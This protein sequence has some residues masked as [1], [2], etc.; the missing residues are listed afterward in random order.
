MGAPLPS[1]G[2]KDDAVDDAP[3]SELLRPFVVVAVLVAVMGLGELI[4]L[5]PGTPFD[6]WGIRPRTGRGLVGIVLAPFLHDGFGHLLA[7]ALPF[8]LMGGAIAA[9]GLGRFVRVAVIVGLVSGAGTW[10][11]GTAGS[12][13]LGASGL[14]FGFL[15]YLMGR[16]LFARN[17]LW[18]AGGVLTLFVY[19]GVLWGLLPR[20]GVSW[21]GHVFGA[22]G[23]V[24][25]AWLLHRRREH[26]GPTAR[27][28][29][30]L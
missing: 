2:S 26:S 28:G 3:V 4:D 14:V 1:P 18:L 6:S 17:L 22:V 16:G 12:V 29:A 20:P 11:V 24:L 10:L 15:T 5:V 7:N 9:S 30:S 23:G 21:T 13:H 8:L 19:G 27:R 25:A